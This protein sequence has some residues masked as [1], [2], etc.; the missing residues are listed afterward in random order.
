VRLNLLDRGASNPVKMAHEN[1]SERENLSS[2]APTLFD[3]EFLRRHRAPEGYF[4]AF[5]VDALQKAPVYPARLK[6]RSLKKRDKVFLYAV[7]AGLAVLI[8]VSYLFEND[9]RTLRDTGDPVVHAAEIFMQFP[10]EMAVYA[11]RMEDGDLWPYVDPETL[12]TPIIPDEMSENELID[13][14]IDDGVSLPLIGSVQA[15]IYNHQNP[16]Q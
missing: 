8:A 6:P 7:A 12:G 14:L 9:I 11:D 16:Q 1:T 10:T 13:Y 4:E 5:K 15:E 3:E 2:I